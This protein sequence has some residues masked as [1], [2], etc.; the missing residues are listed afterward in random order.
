MSETCAIDL[1]V[2]LPRSVAMKI[3]EVQEQKPE[4]L[5]QMLMYTM[6]R[7]TIF[8]RLVAAASVAPAASGGSAA[9][10]A[11]G[12]FAASAASEESSRTT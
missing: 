10:A 12:A 11:S 3:Q 2:Q 4:L 6:A 8:D 1:R 5:S 9:S 7:R